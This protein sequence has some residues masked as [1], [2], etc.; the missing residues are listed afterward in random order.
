MNTPDLRTSLQLV[1]GHEVV[2]VIA[3]FG[4][5]VQGFSKGDR[6]VA[7]PGVTVSGVAPFMRT[8]QGLQ[9]DIPVRNMFLLPKG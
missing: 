2:G 4:K 1:P 3:D 7:D 9:G 6:C 5:N 8:L